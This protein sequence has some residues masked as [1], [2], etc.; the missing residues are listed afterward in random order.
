[1]AENYRPI[2]CDNHDEL[3]AAAVKKVDVELE[4][5][6]RGVRQRERG[7]IVDVYSADGAEYIRLEKPSGSITIRLD[8]IVRMD[9]LTQ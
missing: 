6:Q 4:F 2:S 8:E 5:D 3:E 9:E 1:M 7:K